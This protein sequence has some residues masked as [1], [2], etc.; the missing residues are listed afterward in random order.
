[1]GTDWQLQNL[2]LTQQMPTECPW[3]QSLPK[4]AVQAMFAFPPIATIEW[5]SLVVRFVPLDANRGG[6]IER[7]ADPEISAPDHMAS[8][9]QSVI[10]YC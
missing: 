6:L 3:G 9:F 1:M 5:T 2:I 8:K 10:R 7:D 4:W